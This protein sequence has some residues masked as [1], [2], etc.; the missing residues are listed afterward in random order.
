[1]Y[2]PEILNKKSIIIIITEITYMN[3]NTNYK[4]YAQTVPLT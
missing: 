1:M 2:P 4:K 3:K